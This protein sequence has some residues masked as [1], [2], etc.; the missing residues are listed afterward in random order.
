M[1][2]NLQIAGIYK[3]RFNSYYSYNFEYMSLQILKQTR[4]IVPAVDGRINKNMLNI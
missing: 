2:K 1:I 4:L 3:I